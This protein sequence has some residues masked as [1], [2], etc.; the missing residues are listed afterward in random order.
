[1]PFCKAKSQCST[2]LPA[3]CRS[4]VESRDLFFHRSPL[5]VHCSPLSEKRSL[6]TE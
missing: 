1:L 6:K 3:N 2:I 4:R 5:T